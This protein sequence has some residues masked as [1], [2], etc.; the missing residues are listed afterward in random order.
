MKLIY[1]N[2]KIKIFSLLL[3][4]VGIVSLGFFMQGCSQEDEIAQLINCDF[5]N[6]YDYVGKYHNDGLLYVLN[7]MENSIKLKSDADNI[8]QNAYDFTYEFCQNNPIGN[9]S[10][11]DDILASVI[12]KTK[13]IRLK[14]SDNNFSKTQLLY[15]QKFESILKNPY[16]CSSLSDVLNRI[17]ILEKE[18]YDSNMSNEDKEA[19]LITYAVGRN[20]LEFWVGLNKKSDSPRLKSDNEWDFLD[21]WQKNV[22][23]ALQTIVKGD[24]DGAYQGALAGLYAGSVAGT[25]ISTPGAGTVTGA[26]TGTVYG[27]AYGAIIGSA[28]N[29]VAYFISIAS[30]SGSNSSSLGTINKSGNGESTANTGIGGFK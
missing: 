21:W 12:Q 25:V 19:L 9:V 22:L 26:I 8:E 27:G 1:K 10:F 16:Y 23:P 4:L 15:H 11:S 24:F 20:S 17:R 6:P 13:D 7:K 2:Q 5:Q 29:G 14:S 30:G 18:I 28:W 3:M